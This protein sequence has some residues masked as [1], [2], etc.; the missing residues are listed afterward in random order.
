MTVNISDLQSRFGLIDKGLPDL[1]SKGGKFNTTDIYGASISRK[2]KNAGNPRAGIY[3]DGDSGAI[4]ATDGTYLGSISAEKGRQNSAINAAWTSMGET[5][6]GH[7]PVAFGSG[8]EGNE[9]NSHH[10]IA[11]AIQYAYDNESSKE[12]NPT[13]NEAEFSPQIQDAIERS[14]KYREDNWS[15]K[16]AQDIYGKSKDLAKGAYG[17]RFDHGVDNKGYQAADIA[18]DNYF[19]SEK[20]K[21]DLKNKQAQ[22]KAAQA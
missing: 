17:G 7:K 13:F 16:T 14:N 19:N 5:I 18:T 3:N 10:N 21:M 6:A 1:P 4:Y 2:D 8:K 20:Y 12:E 15:G 11:E 9:L 22:N